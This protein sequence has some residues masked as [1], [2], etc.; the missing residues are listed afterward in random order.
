[1]SGARPDPS[2]RKRFASF[3]AIMLLTVGLLS[4]C[5]SGWQ[6]DHDVHQDQIRPGVEGSGL[7]GPGF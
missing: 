7:T 4:G 3:A 6:A 5:G 2:T 1:M